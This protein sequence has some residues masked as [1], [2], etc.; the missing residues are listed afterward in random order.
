MIIG[1]PG[2][3]ITNAL[4]DLILQDNN[5]IDKINL[6]AK[7]LEEPKYQ[8]LIKKREQAGIKDLNYSSAFMEQSNTMDNIYGFVN[9]YNPK[10]KRSVLIVFD[11][12]I[13]HVMSDKKAQSVLKGPFIR[14]RKSNISFC[15]I[16]QSYFSV[17][18]EVRLNS[19]PY[20]IFKVNDKRELQNI[21]IN[22]SVDVD[23]KDF[24]KT[25]RNCTKEPYCFLSINT[26]LPANDFMKF[27]TKFF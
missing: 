6:Y 1:P 4:L 7:D 19:T 17:P 3:G 15:F 12:L 14:Y 21:A 23:Y 18:K 2:S 25:C 5:I 10:R 24:L 16:I 13:S 11:D 22:Y 20:L 8:L 9:D 27:R 26:T